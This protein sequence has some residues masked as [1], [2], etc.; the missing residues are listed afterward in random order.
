M[1]DNN[2]FWIDQNKNNIKQSYQIQEEPFLLKITKL[3]SDIENKEKLE[4]AMKW[5][6]KECRKKRF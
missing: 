3:S 1:C 4:N 5:S 2:L 6:W